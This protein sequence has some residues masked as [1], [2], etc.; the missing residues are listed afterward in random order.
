MK[1]Y[2][3]KPRTYKSSDEVYDSAMKRAKKEKRKL[4]NII[5]GVVWS[6]ASGNNSVDFEFVNTDKPIRKGLIK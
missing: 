3:R 1:D 4:A 6:Y 5:E 2:S